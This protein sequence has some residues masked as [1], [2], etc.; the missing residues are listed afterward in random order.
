MRK[1]IISAVII[2]VLFYFASFPGKNFSKS[3]STYL[4]QWG[5]RSQQVFTLN[6]KDDIDSTS[7]FQPRE[8]TSVLVHVEG[9]SDSVAWTFIAKA[10]PNN[11]RDSTHVSVPFDTASVTTSG[12]QFLQWNGS[13][14]YFLVSP[15]ADDVYVVIKSTTGNAAVS[16][17]NIRVM[18]LK[19]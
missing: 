7:A 17:G 19:D 9:G 15:A 6:G 18:G 2:S 12:A 3:L 14:N 11:Y 1:Q 4:S 13:Q 5:K 8:Y 10:G 16:S